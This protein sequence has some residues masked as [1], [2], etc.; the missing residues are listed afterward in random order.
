M[1]E[2]PR[3]SQR[4]AKDQAAG[5]ARPVRVLAN[6]DP[7]N[8]DQASGHEVSHEVE[9]PL[10]IDG[11]IQLLAIGVAGGD[12]CSAVAAMLLVELKKGLAGLADLQ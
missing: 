7:F 4:Q 10:G 11:I 12:K 1:A 6:A 8:K 2:H 3:G 5:F 9:M